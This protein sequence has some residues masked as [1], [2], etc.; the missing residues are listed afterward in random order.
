M[1]FEVETP[2]RKGE[3][4]WMQI[5]I[6]CSLVHYPLPIVKLKLFKFISE[7][8][9]YVQ[10]FSSSSNFWLVPPPLPGIQL[11]KGGINFCLLPCNGFILIINSNVWRARDAGRG[12][13]WPLIGQNTLDPASDW[14]RQSWPGCNVDVMA[15]TLT[16]M[17]INII[18]SLVELSQMAV[19]HL[20]T[21]Y[22]HRLLDFLHKYSIL[23]DN[24]D[25][26]SHD[27][28]WQTGLNLGRFL[29]L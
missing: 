25:D 12:W 18:K 10:N 7:E 19:G 1:H 22:L 3:R 8:K 13:C 4:W 27:T 6:Q 16:I 26:T 14:L 9:S 21:V 29:T 2:I 5:Q 11:S 28:G 17:H 23:R 24:K 15:L 20:V